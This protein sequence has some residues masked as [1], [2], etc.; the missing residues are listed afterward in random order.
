[1]HFN[2][3]C[4]IFNSQGELGVKNKRLYNIWAC[5]KQRCNNP[6]YTAA[7]GDHDKGIRVCEEW[8]K[9]IGDLNTFYKKGG[10][11]NARKY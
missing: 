1:M 7:F 4:D 9:Y 11:H 5:M 3:L 2:S 10:E 8:Q 6:N